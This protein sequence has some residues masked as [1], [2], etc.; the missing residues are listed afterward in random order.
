MHPA[1]AILIAGWTCRF[2]QRTAFK[3]WWKQTERPFKKLMTF[4]EAAAHTPGWVD[5]ASWPNW[6]VSQTSIADLK[7]GR[8]H[9]L[10]LG[11]WINLLSG[12]LSLLNTSV[13][14]A[15]PCL[16]M[17]T[18]WYAGWQVSFNKAYEYF[19]NG[20]LFSLTG[21]L[22][23]IVVMFYVPMAQARQAVAGEARRFWQFG[24][25]RRVIRRRWFLCTLLALAYAAAGAVLMVIISIPMSADL[26]DYFNSLPPDKLELS[27]RGYYLLAALFIFPAYVALRWFAARIYASAIGHMLSTGEVRADELSP[28]ERLA[29]PQELINSPA[30]PSCR[31]PSPRLFA[32]R[33]QWSS[34]LH[35]RSS[36]PKSI[37]ASSSFTVGRASG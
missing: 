4:R 7:K 8:I 16:L 20:A 2:M 31:G 22:L 37:L 33:V 18:W 27:I 23:L 32:R 17:A 28:A 36:W 35:G 24:L 25:V 34:S 15:L 9:R 26:Q 21:G 12:L 3:A 14:L 29:F 10:L 1:G 11:L 19:A 5:H 30:T 6:I 13:V